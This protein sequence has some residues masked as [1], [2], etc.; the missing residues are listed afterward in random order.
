MVSKTE[1]SSISA[2]IFEKCQD[3]LQ[4]NRVVLAIGHGQ[5]KQFLM[6]GFFPC[7]KPKKVINSAATSVKMH[8]F[9]ERTLQKCTN[10]C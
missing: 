3:P 6:G 9:V 7:V 1:A 5:L 8:N 2:V 4:S 10:S